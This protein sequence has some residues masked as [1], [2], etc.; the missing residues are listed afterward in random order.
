MSSLAAEEPLQGVA[1]VALAAESQSVHVRL[2]VA[3]AGRVALR[4]RA[5][6]PLRRLAATPTT[7]DLVVSYHETLCSADC[8]SFELVKARFPQ[9]L[10]V[11]VC[12]SADGRAVRRALDSGV[13]GLVFADELEDA[14]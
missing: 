5:T 7:D 10:V 9:L 8:E 13:D 6:G 1:V 12:E 11:A 4:L 3:L 2:S 14:L